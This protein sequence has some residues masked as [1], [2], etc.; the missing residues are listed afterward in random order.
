M[1]FSGS[2][3][4][5]SS[6]SGSSDVALSNPLNSQVLTYNTSVAKWTNATPSAG[7]NPWDYGVYP[8]VIWNGTSWPTRSSSL[9]SGY[10]GAVEY[11]S[12][13]DSSATSPSDRVTGDIWT[14]VG[15]A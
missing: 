4:S 11:W 7:V 10:S 1:S 5:G 3:G 6:V 15:T 12:A 14:R 13:A 8:R 9:P 2:G